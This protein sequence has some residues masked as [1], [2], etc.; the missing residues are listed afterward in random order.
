MASGGQ[1]EWKLWETETF[2]EVR[3]TPVAAGW[4]SFSTDNEILMTAG[5]LAF[6]NQS[7]RKWDIASGAERPALPVQRKDGWNTYHL[8]PDGR[9]VWTVNN[10]PAEGIAHAYDTW[11]GKERGSRGGHTGPVQAVAISPD[12]LTLASG[13]GDCQVLLWDLDTC[14]VLRPLAGHL[15]S[16]QSLVFSR[17]GQRL[18]SG[19]SDGTIILWDVA[20]GTFVRTFK[21]KSGL[22]GRVALSPDGQTVVAGAGDGSIQFWDAASGQEPRTSHYHGSAVRSVAFS[23]DGKWLAS[24]GHDGTIIVVDAGTGIRTASFHAGLTASDMAWSP[25][26]KALVAGT[27]D[28]DRGVIC[29]DVASRQE[30]VWKGPLARLSAVDYQPRVVAFQPQGTFIAAPMVD[31]AVGLWDRG[32][33]GPTVKFGPGPFGNA[34]AGLAFT[35]DGRYLAVAGGNGTICILRAPAPSS[36]MPTRAP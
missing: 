9:T 21:S 28:P 19:S 32:S 8:S 26:G 23:P 12:G 1:T 35:P 29:W 34:I 14:R 11:T 17:D 4:M 5:R 6:Q 20:R 30:M 10:Y 13:A 2:K 36:A 24:A 25:D 27:W 22:L 7:V 3:S 15:S 18:V 16:V 31:M 33:P